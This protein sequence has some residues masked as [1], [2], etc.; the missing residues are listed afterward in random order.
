MNDAATSLPLPWSPRSDAMAHR[1]WPLLAAVAITLLL[2]G[3]LLAWGLDLWVPRATM[4]SQGALIEARLISAPASIEVSKP[5]APAAQRSAPVESAAIAEAAALPRRPSPAIGR[6]ASPPAA[7]TPP[8]Q[9]DSPVETT[10]QPTPDAPNASMQ[11]A[12]AAGYRSA[13]ELDPPP[14]PLGDID[15]EYPANA[16][17]QSGTVVLRLLIGTGGTVDDVT[18]VSA[19]LPGVFDASAIAAF[20]KALFAP[21]R[22]LGVP[23]KSQIT[24]AVDYTP[25]NRGS[26]ISGQGGFGAL[27]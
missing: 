6:A 8:R 2:H 13:T 18:V 14:R 12:L 1:P 23:V 15:P 10:G 4:Q 20:G 25:T 16:G 19:S 26:A 21:G 24:I 27:K 22:Y 5:E 7:P 9:S 3:A 11:A 17:L